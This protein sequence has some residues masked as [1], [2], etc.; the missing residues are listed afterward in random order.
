MTGIVCFLLG[1]FSLS[2]MSHLVRVGS[3]QMDERVLEFVVNHVRN[4]SLTPI[5]KTITFFA[6]TV[7][8]VLLALLS[9][10]F[11]KGKREKKYFLGNLLGSVG[12]S[13]ILKHLL[14][15]PRPFVIYRLV[16][17]TGYSFPSGHSMVGIS[18]YSYFIYLVWKQKWSKGKKVAATIFLSLFILSIGFSR[19]YLGVH[20]MTDVLGGFALGLLFTL[21]WILWKE[22]SMQE[23]SLCHSIRYAWEGILSAF[24]SERNMK[25]HFL[26]M[27]TVIISGFLFQISI[28]EWMICLLLFGLVISLEIMN[29]A[30][31]TTVD[32]AMPEKHL[33]AKLAKDLSAG[34]VLVA[35]IISIFVGFLIFLPKLFS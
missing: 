11:I 20:F 29:T 22:D 3:F 30:I 26:I 9:F 27:L 12:I 31:E 23:K 14:A 32:L 10:F 7:G 25:I 13:Q 4:S 5:F 2:L 6:S 21:L 33:K 19:I 16:E 34:A 18:F 28:L 17:E 15:R 8:I 1:I 24:R 35:A